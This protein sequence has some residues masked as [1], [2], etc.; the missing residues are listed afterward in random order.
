MIDE[1]KAISV[2]ISGLALVV[3]LAN[4]ASLP[5]LAWRLMNEWAI[6]NVAVIF[7]LLVATLL[8]AVWVNVDYNDSD[9]DHRKLQNL[10]KRLMALVRKD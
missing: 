4:M 10:G 8:V 6:V 2:A 5:Q 1:Q 9:N 7:L 3:Y